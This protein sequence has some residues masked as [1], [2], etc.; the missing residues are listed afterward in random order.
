MRVFAIGD[1]HLSYAKPKLMDVFG[2]QWSRHDERIFADWRDRV[3]EKDVVLVPGDISWATRLSEAVPDLEA[4]GR[5]PGKKVLLRGNH[6]YWWTAPA[7]IRRLLPEGVFII[8]ND[9]LAIGE[10]IFCGTRGWTF[11][12]GA[13]LEPEDEKIYQRELIRLQLSLDAARRISTRPPTVLLHFPPLHESWPKT[14]FTEILE[15]AGVRRVVFGHLYGDVLQQIHL[16]GL[17]QGGIRYD[18]V[19]ADYLHFRLFDL[20]M[21]S[22]TIPS[23]E[24][25]IP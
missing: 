22:C 8:Q 15:R 21:G 11:P 19:S 7:K 2:P 18:L 13:P 16:R 24:V 9:A 17:E 5:L 10:H 1:L 23:D 25:L 3:S 6:D 4:L 14:G 20:D 12:T